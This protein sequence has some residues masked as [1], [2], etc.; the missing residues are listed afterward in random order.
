MNKAIVIIVTL[1]FGIVSFV[2]A[3]GQAVADPAYAH[4]GSSLVSNVRVID[5]LG[6]DPI[7][8]QD[9]LIVDGKIAAIGDTGSLEAPDGAL[10]IDGSGLTAM[11]GLIDMHVHLKGGWANATLPAE[12]YQPTYDDKAI[13]RALS[14]YLY[15]GVTTV[16]EVGAEDHD[17]SVATRDR[18]NSGDLFGPR[19][20]TVGAPW[21]QRPSGWDHPGLTYVTDA[22]MIPDQMRQYEDADIEMLKLYTGMSAFTAQLVVEAAHERGMY[23]VADLWQL[24]MDQ[25]YMRAS[26]LNGFAHSSPDSVS[27]ESNEWLAA[28]DRFVIATANVGEKLSGLR[29][30][31]EDGQ[32]L[33]LNEPLIVDIWG[34]DTVTEFYDTYPEIRHEFYDGPNAFYQLNNFGDMTKIRGNFL[35][36]IKGAYDAGVLIAGGSDSP[37]PSVWAGESMHR[38]LELFVMAGIPEIDAIKSCTYNA[39]KIL[40]RD[41]EF[42]SLQPGMS[43]DILIVEGN[44]AINISNSRNVRHVFSQGRQVD[45]DSL[46]LK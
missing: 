27:V 42:G 45:R 1:V 6:N 9:I 17:W 35:P 31:D 26:G 14:G 40:R 13:Q 34:K 28:N 3:S 10:N 19:A 29:V 23:V 12:K 33:M 4:E 30:A 15:A 2:L 43:A 5:G 22:E 18:I 41:A 24:N 46:K 39:A 11:P 25:I 38:E 20:Y 37:F 21:S 32:R 36:N 44:P 16:L 7:E 8:S